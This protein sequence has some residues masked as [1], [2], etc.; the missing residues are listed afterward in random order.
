MTKCNMCENSIDIS[1]KK[2]TCEMVGSKL[3]FFCNV[4][5]WENFNDKTENS[6]GIPRPSK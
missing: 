5:C 2:H 1:K 6:K 3:V 4:K